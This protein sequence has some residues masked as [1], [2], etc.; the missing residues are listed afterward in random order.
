MENSSENT[1][2]VIPENSLKEYFNKNILGRKTS[3]AAISN[4][5]KRYLST[6]NPELLTEQ[7]TTELVNAYREGYLEG[8]LVEEYYKTLITKMSDLLDFIRI[9]SKAKNNESVANLLNSALMNKFNS[10]LNLDQIISYESE[11]IVKEME[12][13]KRYLDADDVKENTDVE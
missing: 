7:A 9:Y 10:N 11:D 12:H 6:I 4:S 8:A 2:V 5:F 1:E 3:Q 13:I